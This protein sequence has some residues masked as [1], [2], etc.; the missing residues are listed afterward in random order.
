VECRADLDEEIL[1]V[2]ADNAQLDQVVMSL[3]LNAGE[4]M[5]DGGTLVIR[6]RKAE[7][8]SGG[9]EEAA[10]SAGGAAGV[11]R[12]GKPLSG[13]C[14]ILEVSDTGVGMDRKTMERIF[15]PF[16]STKFIGRG[17]G[18]AAVR[19]IVENHD[20]EILVRSE[21]GK[22]TT[23]AIGFPAARSAPVEEQESRASRPAG[24]SGVVLVADDENDVRETVAAMLQSLGYRV[25]EARSGMEALEVFRERSGEIDLV[26]LDL[27]MPRMTGDQAFAEMQRISPGVRGILASGYDE[28]ERIRE[29]LAGGLGGFLRKPFR[30]SELGRKVAEILGASA[31]PQGPA[32]DA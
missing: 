26:L 9:I 3:C 29:V 6:T 20:G 27:M 12:S 14:S 1:P 21:P 25:I 17:M 19:G 15:E 30:R 16:F 22:G 23:F 13:P 31:R 24:S 32:K 5:P 2:Q 7:T 8:L 4:A 11:V 10:A 28:S 18:L